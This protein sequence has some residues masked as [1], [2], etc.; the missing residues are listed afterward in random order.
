MAANGL[1]LNENPRVCLADPPF[2][3][4]SQNNCQAWENSMQSCK[5]AGNNQTR[6]EM[7]ETQGQLNELARQLLERIFQDKGKRAVFRALPL[8]K[9][10]PDEA[11]QAQSSSSSA[12]PTQ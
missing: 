1:A 6:V 8:C 9:V 4:K 11:E 12:S 5:G 2:F 10:V 3:F 7:A